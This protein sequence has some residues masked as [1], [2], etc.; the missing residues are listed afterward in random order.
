[1]ARDGREG[2]ARAHAMPRK[3]R[4][5][6]AEIAPRPEGPRHAAHRQPGAARLTKIFRGAA[7]MRQLHSR[8]PQARS[9]KLAGD[10]TPEVSAWQSMIR[11]A[12]TPAF[13]AAVMLGLALTWLGTYAPSVLTWL[14]GG[15]HTD[16]HSA[17]SPAR[18]THRGTPRSP[19]STAPAVGVAKPRSGALPTTGDRAPARQDVD[20]KVFAKLE[21]VLAGLSNDARPPQHPPMSKPVPDSTKVQRSTAGQPGPKLDAPLPNTTPTDHA[22]APTIQKP[23]GAKP[24]PAT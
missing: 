3:Q 1:M 2:Q 10:L 6:C 5:Q 21:E 23:V 15:A 4:A 11:A 24:G 22:G 18:P 14:D 12:Q 7:A 16:L 13:S 8:T 9:P 19:A 20:P 17:H